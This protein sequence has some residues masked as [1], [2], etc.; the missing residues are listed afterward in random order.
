M[1]WKESVTRREPNTLGKDSRLSRSPSQVNRH[2][3]V[4]RQRARTG[5]HIRVKLFID[6]WTAG[7]VDCR[8]RTARHKT[9][10]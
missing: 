10:T 5:L 9:V 4:Y 2:L 8:T 1:R 3:V 7:L 6:I